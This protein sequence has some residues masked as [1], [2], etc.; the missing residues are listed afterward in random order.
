MALEDAELIAINTTTHDA[1][2]ISNSSPSTG[3]VVHVSTP[4]LLLSALPLLL[5]A[6]FGNDLGIRNNVLIATVRCFT[7]LLFLGM[8]LHPIFVMGI[9]MPWLVG[10][11]KLLAQCCF[12]RHRKH[13]LITIYQI[14]FSFLSFSDVLV[15]SL[16]ATKE[17]MTRVKYT[18]QY[19][20]T[21]TFLAMLLSII[22]VGSLA[23]YIVIRPNP[24]WDPQYVIPICG[25]LLGNCIS[26]VSLTVNNLTRDIVDS[27]QREI[28]LLLSFGASGWESMARLVRVAIDAGTTP[29]IN[30][31]NVIGLVSIPGMMTGQILGGSSIVEAAHYQ[32]LIMYLI[33]TCLFLA[34]FTNVFIL[35][36]VA[37]DAVKHVLRIDRFI[38]I[39]DEKKKKQKSNGWDSIASMIRK[40]RTKLLWKRQ[41]GT[42][43]SAASTTYD[44]VNSVELD[45]E[46][47]ITQPMNDYETASS[48]NV[49]PTNRITILTRQFAISRRSDESVPLFQ[50]VNLTYSVPKSHMKKQL[51]DTDTNEPSESG[52]PLSLFSFRGSSK[53]QQHNNRLCTD[54]NINLIKG[55]IGVIK[56]PSGCGKST[57]LRVLAGLTP[58]DDGD[59][60]NSAI[61]IKSCSMVGWRMNVRYVTQYKVD[62]PGTPRDFIYRIASLQFHSKYN[63]PTEEV[64]IT[65]S[66]AYLQRWGME[67]SSS[68][69]SSS[70]YS[71]KADNNN[72]DHQQQHPLEREWKTLS[73]GESQRM[74]LAIAMA[75]GGKVLLLDEATSGLDDATQRIVEESVVEYVKMYDAAVLWVTHSEDIVER[76]LSI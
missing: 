30:N 75:S 21:M 39:M 47:V 8:I 38:E 58:M 44:R 16:I 2:V 22:V 23:F 72:N 4:I 54:L 11:C 50:V 55:E 32:I 29:I 37:F 67:G 6:Y 18:Y 25:M 52:S 68:S 62:L 19:H 28:E 48:I 3:G 59:V 26:G 27:G 34:V 40:L 9:H 63:S 64:M 70:E 42:R 15:M 17:S 10:L 36:H 74:L 46:D 73:G 1:E 43:D 66:L 20:A 24:R 13:C 33:A 35:Y 71:N 51:S 5:I 41:L 56:G 57:L 69:S 12:F 65:Q 60:I 14:N 61:S 53:Q 31:M 7:Q 45:D 49:V 76:L